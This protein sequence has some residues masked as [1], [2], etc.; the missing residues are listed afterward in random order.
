MQAPNFNALA[1]ISLLA[2]VMSLTYSTIGIGGSIKAGKQPG[3]TYNVDGHSLADGIFGAFNALGCVPAAK[4][5]T[6]R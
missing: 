4:T 1:G 2:A 5:A 3:T 6:I